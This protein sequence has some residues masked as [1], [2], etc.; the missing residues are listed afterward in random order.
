M[1]TLQN[2]QAVIEAIADFGNAARVSHIGD[3]LL[4]CLA[5][6]AFGVGFDFERVKLGV[7]KQD[8]IGNA[9]L[10]TK[11]DKPACFNMVSPAAVSRMEE[12]NAA[13][14]ASVK[15]LHDGAVYVGFIKRH[16]RSSAAKHSAMAVP[17]A[18]ES[19]RPHEFGALLFAQPAPAHLA[20]EFLNLCPFP[21]GDR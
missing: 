13:R 11:P 7:V 9:R 16:K 17:P 15:V 6:F 1:P 14:S 18:F 8:Q 3:K 19:Q 12:H 10:N 4:L 21:I 2:A 20:A 5:D